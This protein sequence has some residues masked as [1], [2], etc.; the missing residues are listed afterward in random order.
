MTAG[1]APRL[2]R[3]LPAADAL[4]AEHAPAIGDD[5]AG[6]RN[7]VY[8]VANLCLA[9]SGADGEARERVEVAA[10]LHDVGIWTARTF[11]YLAP[12]AAVAADHLRRA[13]RAAW[14]P[15][16]TT[17]IAEHHRVR[18]YRGAG[19]LV[20]PFRRADW[21]DV[22]WGAL[23]LGAP[24]AF[25]RAV[26]AAWPDAGFHRRLAALT[27]ARARVHPLSPLPMLRL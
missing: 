1:R 16:V 17:M 6:Y 13:G 21:I 15:E 22:S 19:A 8:R 12:S 10:A 2:H 3:T 5:L 23:A 9:L 11:D 7:H 20:E 26:R 25:V 24:R 18:P 4:L 27:L 14:V